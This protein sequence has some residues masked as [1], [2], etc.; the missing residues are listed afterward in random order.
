VR[1]VVPD[2]VIEEIEGE[3][4]I[5]VNDITVPRLGIKLALRDIISSENPKS[6]YSDQKL[7]D[8]LKA[9]NMEI[10]RRTVAKYRDELGISATSVRKRY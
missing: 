6:P 5:L 3:F 1:Y 9:R 8:L 7:A 10:S 4:I 2:V